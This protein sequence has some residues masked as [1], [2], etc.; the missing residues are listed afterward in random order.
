LAIDISSI[1]EDKELSF[2]QGKQ[3]KN[4]KITPDDM[5]KIMNDGILEKD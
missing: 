4:K 2:G 1:D 3:Y 5:L